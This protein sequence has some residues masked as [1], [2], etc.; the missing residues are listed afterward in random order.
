MVNKFPG[1]CEKCGTRV[2]KG[3]GTVRKVGR[4]FWAVA[5]NDCGVAV[6]YFPQSGTT[7]TVNRGGRCEDAPCCGCC[8]TGMSVY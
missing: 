3:D 4:K 1:Q 6:A 5:H 7:M 8:S 2:S